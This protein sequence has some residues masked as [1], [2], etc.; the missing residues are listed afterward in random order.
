MKVSIQEII[1]YSKC[2]MLHYHK[3]IS[4][5]ETPYT[6]INE[7]YDDE[8][9]K[10]LYSSFIKY[11][12]TERIS[13]SSVMTLWGKHWIKDVRR[14]G[15]LT[16]DTNSRSLY[17]IKRLKG[18]HSLKAMAERF[19]GFSH[20]VILCNKEYE[21]EVFKNLYITGNIELLTEEE[22]ADKSK[23]LHLF[24]FKTDENAHNKLNNEY[25][26]K[27]LM[28]IIA[29]EELIKD[30][31]IKYN[32]YNLDK[33]KMITLNEFRVHKE[34]FR[35]SVYN[36][37]YLIK[38]KVY[39]MVPDESCFRCTYRDVCSKKEN[40]NIKRIGGKK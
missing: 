6:D 38:N 30:K 36:I 26:Y 12:D 40:V 18:I 29:S 20:K 34:D 19:D 8:I 1:D 11:R 32:I 23:S 7:K 4:K 13:L 25:E 35:N 21:I 39:Y 10:V 2:P 5:I 17:N 9:H 15:L 27:M 16:V 31:E 28:S 33:D 22:K 24:V 3:Y 37:A 14:S